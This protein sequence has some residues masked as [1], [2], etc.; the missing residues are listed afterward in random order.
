MMISIV[1]DSKGLN[2]PSLRI[3]C[4]KGFGRIY[5]FTPLFQTTSNGYVGRNETTLWKRI[6]GHKTPKSECVALSSAIKKHGLHNFRLS[7]L[8]DEIPVSKLADA[9]FKYVEMHDTFH[10]G[11]NCT[12]G[13]EAPPLLCPDV[14][15]KVKATK[16]TPESKA[17]TAAA[18]RKHWNNPVEH[19]KH[20]E[21]LA[22]SRRDPKVREKTSKATTE[23][24]TRD[25]YKERLSAIHKVSQNKPERKKQLSKQ[26][27]TL[28]SDPD[29]K[30]SR[31]Q[32]IKDGRARAKAAR[33]GVKKYV[34][35]T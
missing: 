16:N 2:H 28:W 6:Q 19:K 13:G 24:W 12:P 15:A 3:A 30:K 10:N 32:A 29:Y 33:G 35:R 1:L 8:E 5:K 14:A 23:V 17:K 9:E 18:S 34:R 27:T 25:G 31:S 11:Y 22:K 26:M 4:R 7:V 20:A 21:S